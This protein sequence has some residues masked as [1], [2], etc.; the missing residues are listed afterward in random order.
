MRI[1]VLFVCVCSASLTDC[2]CFTRAEYILQAIGAGA[3]ATSDRDW[4]QTWTE[5]SEAEKLQQEI[6]R[7]HAEG[8]QRPPVETT[9]KR[10]FATSWPYQVVTLLHRDMQA[11]WR[12]PTYVMSKMALNIVG[13]LFIGFTFWKAKDSLQGTQNKLFVRHALARCQLYLLTERCVCRFVFWVSSSVDLHGHDHECPPRAAAA[14]A[15]HHHAR[16]V[17]SA[18]TPEQDVQLDGARH[19]ADPRGGAV[20]HLWVVHVLRVLVLDRRVRD[21]CAACGV[22]VPRAGCAVP[23]VLHYRR[24][25]QS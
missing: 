15:V 18:R 23:V 7:I 9:L 2:L 22:C 25:G 17:R 12:D 8:R 4:H 14:G 24:A 11:H 19:V 5:S 21:D 1:L 10:K 20:E 16:P 13:G 3:T 6:E